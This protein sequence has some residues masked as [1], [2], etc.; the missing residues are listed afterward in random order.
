M[1]KK[2][3]I[4]LC[5]SIL[6]FRLFLFEPFRIPSGSMIPT[7][8]IGDFIIVNKWP[9]FGKNFK[10]GDVVVFSYPKDKTINFIKRIVGIPG[11]RLKIEQGRIIIND[12]PEKLYDV[13]NLKDFRNIQ[14]QYSDYSLHFFKTH[15]ANR[16]YAIQ[17][18]YFPDQYEEIM[19]P[20]GHYF[21]MGDNRDFSYD[22]R[23]WGPLKEE[24]IKGKALFVWF[25]LAFPSEVGT[26]DFKPQRIGTLIK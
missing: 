1:R 12:K 15:L 23:F 10:R 18:S 6:V 4:L 2:Y 9:F 24:L 7:L 21:V 19:I 5:L 8:M 13:N 26:W 22:S 14:N 11:D 25:S 16:E 3:L 20:K 17:R